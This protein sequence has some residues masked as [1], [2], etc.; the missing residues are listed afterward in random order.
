[1]LTEQDRIPFAST[2]STLSCA[3]CGSRTFH[4]P[5]GVTVSGDVAGASN[6]VDEA[7]IVVECDGCAGRQEL[8]GG[9]IGGAF[10]QPGESLPC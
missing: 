9:L 3:C 6:E 8:I 5:L 7:V 4:F 2:L 1:M 10:A